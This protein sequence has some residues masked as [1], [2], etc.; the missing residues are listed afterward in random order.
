M[1]T[2]F[3]SKYQIKDMCLYHE[4]KPTEVRI[5]DDYFYL[6]SKPLNIYQEDGHIFALKPLLP[7]LK[8]P[9]VSSS[10]ELSVDAE[11]IIWARNE[12]CIFDQFLKMG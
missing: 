7:F 1:A 8:W 10:T 9:M 5:D 2:K 11:G 3:K 4:G 12:S 6:G